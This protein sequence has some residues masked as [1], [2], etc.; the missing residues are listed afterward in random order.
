MQTKE[1]CDA[2]PGG[3]PLAGIRV[4][5]LATFIAA[6][7]AATVMAEFGADIVKV[8]LPGSGDPTRRFGSMTEAG[9]TL[10]WLSEAR[11]KRSIALDLRTAEGGRQAERRDMALPTPV[12]QLTGIPGAIRWLG[13]A[14]D[15]DAPAILAEG[16]GKEAAP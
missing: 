4:L 14:L 16:L 2:E 7:Y 10:P 13:P 9:E 11:N 15:A 1:T 5:D 12:P 6:P 3:G 8:E